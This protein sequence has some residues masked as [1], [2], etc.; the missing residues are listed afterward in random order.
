MLGEVGFEPF[1]KLTPGKHN[2]SSAAFTL[3]PNIRAQAR[4]SPFVGT[5]G[6]LFTKAQVV[7]ELQVGEH[8]SPRFRKSF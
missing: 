3:Q 6:M 4:N 7:V 5:A 1:G 2:T 8:V